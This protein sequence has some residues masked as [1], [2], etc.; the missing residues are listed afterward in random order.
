M[1]S[2]K[3]KEPGC[4]GGV[5]L[6]SWR[7]L[8]AGAGGGGGGGMEQVTVLQYPLMGLETAGRAPPLAHPLLEDPQ[9]PVG[10]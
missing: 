10:E 1:V 7:P 2:L 3:L 4:G 5:V 9:E 6:K 8:G